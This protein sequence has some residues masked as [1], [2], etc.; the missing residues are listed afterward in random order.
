[1]DFIC[2]GRKDG[3]AFLLRESTLIADGRIPTRGF[4]TVELFLDIGEDGILHA[5]VVRMQARAA[6]RLMRQLN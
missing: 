1:V 4:G 3:A 6:R 5:H 2:H